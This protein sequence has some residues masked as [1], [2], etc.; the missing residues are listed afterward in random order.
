MYI[1]NNNK[2]ENISQLLISQW[3]QFKIIM[4]NEPKNRMCS[5]FIIT[6]CCNEFEKFLNI[7]NIPTINTEYAPN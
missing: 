3:M 6:D 1:K 4:F 5:S 2:L 7:V